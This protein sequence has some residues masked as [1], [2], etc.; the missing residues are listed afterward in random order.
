MS[1]EEYDKS[2][3]ATPFKLREARK[4]GQVAKSIEMNHWL[5]LCALLIGLAG[6]WHTISSDFTQLLTV[7]WLT[8]NNVLFEPDMS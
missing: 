7:L 1:K 4:K 8:G 2:E 5:V 6:F 3:E